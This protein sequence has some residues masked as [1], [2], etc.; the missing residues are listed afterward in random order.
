MPARLIL[1]FGAGLAETLLPPTDRPLN[2]VLPDALQ[3]PEVSEALALWVT[4]P[5][6]TRPP[7]RLTEW[8]VEV[9]AAL[10]VCPLV[11]CDT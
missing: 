3:E 9:A 5:P 10:D 11:D 6:L 4:V 8:V 1:V 7:R 2:V